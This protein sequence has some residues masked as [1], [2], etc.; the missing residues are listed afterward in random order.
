MEDIIYT[1]MVAAIG[2]RGGGLP[3]VRCKEFDAL[4][5][6]IF[7]KEDAELFLQMPDDPFSAETLTEI[8]GKDIAQV[9]KHLEEM[10]DNGVLISAEKDGKRI[11][12]TMALLPGM[13][14]YHFHRFNTGDRARKSAR[15]F[16]D[17]RDAVEK[18]EADTP[19]IFPTVPW[20]RVIPLN[21]DIDSNIQIKTYD[22]VRKYI[23]KAKN[24]ALANCYCRIMGELL[25]NPCQKPKEVCIA[26][27]PGAVSMAEHGFARTI[28][29]DE[30][31]KVL[32]IA[33]Q[34]GLVHCSSNTGKYIDFICNC[35]TC[36]C[37]LLRTVKNA[38]IPSFAASSSVMAEV[39][40]GECIGCEACIERCP[41]EALISK[42]DLV[43]VDN[44]RCI[45]CGLCITTCPAGAIVLR[46]RPEGLPPPYK[47]QD[48]NRDIIASRKISG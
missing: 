41:M 27:G 34:A 2:H 32:D 46:N 23:D 33:D 9:T 37:Y 12:I 20:A 25:D 38:A 10:A 15:I 19:G 36:H 26:F 21:V 5:D 28:S 13:Y 42:N 35:C 48:L 40:A 31:Y 24:I 22:Q 18:I 17:Y 47:L 29:R 44:K 1:K 39:V 16:R 45:G 3:S 7:T 8:T 43:A 11:Y 14:E 30:A 4:I 6:D